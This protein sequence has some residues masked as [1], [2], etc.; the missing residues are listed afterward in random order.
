MTLTYKR[1][2]A[3]LLSLRSPLFQIGMWVGLE[4]PAPLMSTNQRA[5]KQSQYR[6]NGRLELQINGQKV[7]LFHCYWASYAD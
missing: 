6:R 3:H 1:I 2:V 4:I 5:A 7:P